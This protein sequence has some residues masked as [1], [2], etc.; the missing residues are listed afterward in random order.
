MVAIVNWVGDHRTVAG[1]VK[2]AVAVGWK[3]LQVWLLGFP[4]QNR[5]TPY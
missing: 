1:A 4:L 2:A 5:L 3:R